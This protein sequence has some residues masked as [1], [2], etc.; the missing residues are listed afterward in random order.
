MSTG[1]PRAQPSADDAE[2]FSVDFA[3]G[4]KYDVDEIRRRKEAFMPDGEHCW[5]ITAVY[6]I[7]D[8]DE[9]MDSM[10]LGPEN[11]VGVTPLRCLL[12]NVQYQPTIRHYKCSQ[13]HD[14]DEITR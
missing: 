2:S 5:V 7:D 6:G 13:S 1:K 9:A 4:P 3:T 8:P 10:S 11:F 12:C 14:A